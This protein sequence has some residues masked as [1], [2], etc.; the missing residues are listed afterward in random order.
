[1]HAV[2]YK[3]IRSF[4]AIPS[5]EGGNRV[6]VVVSDASGGES[7]RSSSFTTLDDGDR[8]I[9]SGPID[10]QQS[11]IDNPGYEQQEMQNHE[12]AQSAIEDVRKY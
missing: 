6:V 5:F 12:A 10:T 3:R 7:S 8:T 2:S 1:M 11:G 9:I 4:E